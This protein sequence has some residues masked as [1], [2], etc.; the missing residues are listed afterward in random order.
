L[1]YF[2]YLLG[3][4]DIQWIRGLVMVRV[5]WPGHPELKKKEKN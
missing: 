1:W 5:S 2:T 3:L 4:Q